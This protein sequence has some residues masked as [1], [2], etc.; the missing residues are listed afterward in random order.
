[1]EMGDLFKVL[2]ITAPGLP[3]PPGFGG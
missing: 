2:A 3:V 1:V